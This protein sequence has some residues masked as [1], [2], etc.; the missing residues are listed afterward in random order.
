MTMKGVGLDKHLWGN[1]SEAF[2]LFYDGLIEYTDYRIYY[3]LN[4]VEW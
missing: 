3:D 4:R 2:Y 1:R